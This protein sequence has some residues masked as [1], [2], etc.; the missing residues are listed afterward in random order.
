MRAQ[1]LKEVAVF[2]STDHLSAEAVAAYVDNELSPSA[3]R[4][5][6]THL[7][8]CPECRE[9]VAVQR[10]AAE[11]VR[12]SNGQDDVRAP[13]SLVARL[14]MLCEEEPPSTAAGPQEH[15]AGYAAGH[16]TGHPPGD[17]TVLH[18]VESAIRSLRPRG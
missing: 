8:R 16:A 18:K 15:A 3:T 10:R 12:G 14:A 6:N 17:S 4:R 9:D 11:R 7:A 5:A 2:A 13:R 1:A